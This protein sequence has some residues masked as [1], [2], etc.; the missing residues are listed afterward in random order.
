MSDFKVGSKVR[1][2]CGDDKLRA[3]YVSNEITDNGV[4]TITKIEEA[5]GWLWDSLRF[6]LQLEGSS[7]GWVMDDM[8]ELVDECEY[9]DGDE[10]CEEE[11]KEEGKLYHDDDRAFYTPY[12]DEEEVAGLDYESEY[13]DLLT[14][15]Q[16]LDNKYITALR[17]IKEMSKLLDEE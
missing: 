3:H 16:D 4:Y 11:E 15:Y 5:D 17:T 14:R 1:V 7:T 10:C 13:H 9:G 12:F 6:H 8:V 2:I